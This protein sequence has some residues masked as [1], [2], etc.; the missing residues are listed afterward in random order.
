VAVSDRAKL[1]NV[2]W[3]VSRQ[4]RAGKLLVFTHLGHAAPTAVSVQLG[5]GP[6]TPLPPLLGTYLK[7]RHGSRLV[8]I[9]H[10]FAQDD[11]SCGERRDPAPARSLEGLFASLAK[12][13]F[14]LDLRAAPPAVRERLKPVHALY[15]Q[16]PVHSLRLDEG[17][18]IVLFTQRATRSMPCPGSAASR[19]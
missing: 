16:Q 1:G 9:G 17:V 13:A 7:R 3:I 6:A 5:A 14:V 4:G 11:T 10:L 15:G 12:P 18:D 2:E 19:K 8:T